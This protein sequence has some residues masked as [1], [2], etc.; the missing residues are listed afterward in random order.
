MLIQCP[1]CQARANLPES[2]EG[3][4]V[5]CGA[6]GRVYVARAPGSRSVAA[7]RSNG[8]T[9]GLILGAVCLLGLFGWFLR[10]ND[11]QVAGPQAAAPVVEELAPVDY[12]GWDSAPV[13]AVR[14]LFEA[15]ESYELARIEKLIVIDAFWAEQ[16]NGRRAEGAPEV[17]AADFLA[18]DELTRFELKEAL[19]RELAETS[20][21]DA[22]RHWRPVDGSVVEERESDAVVH[23]QVDRRDTSQGLESRTLEFALNKPSS[24]W[25]IAGWQRYVPPEEQRAVSARAQKEYEKVELSDGSVLY[26]A[27]PRPLEHLPDTPPELRAKIDALYARMIDL[28]LTTESADAR[29]ELVRIGKPALPILL[30]GLYEIPIDTEEHAIQVNSIDLALQ[31]ITGEYMGYKPM[32]MAGSTSGTSEEHRQAAIKAWFAWWLRKGEKFE[33]KR[34]AEVDPLEALIELDDRE[35]RLLERDARSGG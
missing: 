18:L 11:E 30:T 32:A 3:A 12:E 8:L 22:L 23:V 20:E 35:K 19:V 31:G 13:R 16:Q 10:S 4:K 28:E 34:E 24:T 9:L 25:K 15:L 14:D 1:A 5:R 26:V 7:T 27:E 2:Q 33:A 17:I 29:E 6:C 21:P